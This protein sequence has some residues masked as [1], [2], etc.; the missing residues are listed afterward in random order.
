MSR[1]TLPA[2]L[3]ASLVCAT[4]AMAT[5]NLVQNG[6]FELSTNGP[7][8]LG[9]VTEATDWTIGDVK[10]SS[11]QHPII[12]AAWLY[13]PGNSYATGVPYGNSPYKAGRLWGPADGSPNGFTDSPDG[14]NFVG[15]D[16]ANPAAPLTQDLTQLVLGRNYVVTF[17]YAL[18]TNIAAVNSNSQYVT[19]G[20]GNQTQNAPTLT[21]A[22]KGFTGWQKET[23]T[24]K[25][26]QGSDVLSFLDHGPV[27]LPPV[28]LIDGVS[29]TPATVP[30]PAIWAMMIVGVAGVGAMARRRRGL[31]AV[32]PTA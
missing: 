28:A 7:G 5:T 9:F 31:T 15:L 30:E 27:G 1:T 22:G 12:G 24:F 2:I 17:Y 3:I 32:A 25:D 16:G 20:L 26:V 18:A 13:G 10:G 6:S 11:K 8:A 29:V 19:V 21:V 14:G 4:S 23:L